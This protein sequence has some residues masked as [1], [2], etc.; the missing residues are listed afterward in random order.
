MI[1]AYKANKT[2]NTIF[3]N[4]KSTINKL[5]QNNVVYEIKCLGNNEQQCEK[6]Y[7]G[8][9]KRSLETRIKEHETD[10]SKEKE[11]T[12]LSQHTKQYEH[13]AELHG[14][15]ILDKEKRSTTR[16]TIGSLRIQ[17]KRE[18]VMNNQ[19]DFDNANF[20]YSLAL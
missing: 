13:T 20:I 10:I 16:Y 18:Y 3:T 17:H 1:P 9:T 7:I 12:G 6:V 5:Q 2:L 4:T 8:T 11:S 19:E 14:V 15:K